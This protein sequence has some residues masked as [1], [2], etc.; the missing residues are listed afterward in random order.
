M[1]HKFF[2]F[3]LSTIL[4]S[5]V[6]NAECLQ[7]DTRLLIHSNTTNG[8]TT[9]VDSSNFA[10]T[11]TVNGDV[12][13]SSAISPQDGF[14]ATSL[15]FDG[16]GD[17]LSIDDP[18]NNLD[19]S[20]WDLG[21][22]NFTI[23]FWVNIQ[24]IK[25]SYIV[26]RNDYPGSITSEGGT[27]GTTRF[28][29]TILIWLDGSGNLHCQFYADASDIINISCPAPAVNEWHHIAIVRYGGVATLYI[30]GSSQVVDT[31]ASG[32]LSEEHSYLVLGKFSN[33]SDTAMN[34][35]GYI[36]EFRFTKGYALWTQNFTPET[37]PCD[38]YCGNLVSNADIYFKD[39]NYGFGVADPGNY[40]LA[41]EGK[42]GAREL[43]ITEAS[44]ADYVF[45]EKYKLPPLSQVE[46]YI[47]KNSHLPGMPSE[48][49]IME[50]GLPMAN[51]MAKQM[52]KIEELTLYVIQMKK[53]ND[54]LKAENEKME[55]R[56]TDLENSQ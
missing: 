1:I 53:E 44:W 29:G 13:H 50:N 52:Q 34:F 9:V 48:K 56:L 3:V 16:N 20:E 25:E 51:M 43:V 24:T 18:N 55:A 41:V 22:G 45:K 42:I 31:S 7:D 36:D 39:G 27:G 2:I 47:L 46:E 10:Y 17:F 8:D 37:Y 28:Q 21:D 19:E 5:S 33:Y 12:H 23:D 49:E 30:D 54:L 40:K 6:T 26:S 38:T 11:I 4:I 14:G 15:Y 35:H 32:D